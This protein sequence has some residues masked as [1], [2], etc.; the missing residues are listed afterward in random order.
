MGGSGDQGVDLIVESNGKRI[1]VQA[2]GY[3]HAV[4]NKAVQE[5]YTGMVHHRCCACVVITNSRFTSSA[6]ELAASTNCMLIGEDEFPD[7][8]MGKLDLCRDL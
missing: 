8:V 6:R 2:K 3:L 1:A 4:S 7:F 5:A